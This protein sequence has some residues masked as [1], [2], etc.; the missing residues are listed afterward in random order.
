MLVWT[1]QIPV[2]EIG[3]ENIEPHRTAVL[4]TFAFVYYASVAIEF[5]I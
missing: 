3:E 2:L 5:I 1:K 4:A